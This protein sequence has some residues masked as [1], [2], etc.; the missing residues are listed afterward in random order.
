MVG[1]VRL[2]LHIT[3]RAAWLRARAAGEYRPPSLDSEGFIHCSSVEQVVDTANRYFR[4]GHGLVLLCIDRDRLDA[5]VRVEAAPGAG[6]GAPAFPH[7]HGPL[8]V[9]AVVGIID[10]AP[11]ADGTFSLPRGLERQRSARPR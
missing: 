3:E 5:E 6:P 8:P 1:L 7:I 10:F 11:D 9:S 2:I 4:G